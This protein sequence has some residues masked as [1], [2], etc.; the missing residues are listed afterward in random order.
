MYL[1]NATAG[2]A[3]TMPAAYSFM[4]TTKRAAPVNTNPN[5]K[6]PIYVV[7]VTLLSPFLPKDSV[8]INEMNEYERW[9]KAVRIIFSTNRERES[10]GENE[11]GD[12]QYA[13]NYA[14]NLSRLQ[15]K[16]DYVSSQQPFEEYQLD[17]II[18]EMERTTGHQM[19][20]Q[21]YT[22]ICKRKPKNNR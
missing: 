7:F 10:K 4:C 8:K 22:G 16:R 9:I 17:T 6:R 20:Q 12:E 15:R 21:G 19:K 18:S 11:C 14:T 13:K 2:N 5:K 1:V 3:R